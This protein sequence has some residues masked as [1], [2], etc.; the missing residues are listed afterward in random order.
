MYDLAILD[1]NVNIGD[2]SK[3]KICN[4]GIKDSKISYIGNEKINASKVINAVGYEVT[5]GFIDLHT[6]SD[7]SFIVDP[8]ADSKLV[9][10]VTFELMGNCGMSF[11]SPLSKDN[12]YQLQER[13]NRYGIKKNMD[14]NNFD[15]WLNEIENNIPSINVAAQIGHGNLR[16]Y[17]MGMEARQA[18]PEEI[19]EMKEEIQ[20]ACDQGVLGFSTGLWYAPGSYSS[21]E[22]IIELARIASKN[23]ILY[24]SHIRSES[25]DSSGLFPAHAEAI[26]IA[27]RSD[28]RVQISHVKSVGPKF[29]GRGYELIEGIEKARNESLDV[30]GDQYPYYWSSTPISGCMFPRW[31]LEGGRNKTIN[32]MKDLEIRKKI[33][34][35]TTNYIN[36]FHGPEGCILADYPS[37]K[38]FEGLNLNEISKELNTSPEEAV[39]QL[40]EKSE[41]SF[42]LHSMEEKDV[43]EIAKYKYMCVASDGNSLR[44][45][46]PLSSGKPHPRS[47]GTNTRFI[48]Q[49]VSNKKIVNFEEAIFRM[50]S[51]PA[52][53]MALKRRGR[54]ALNYFADIN[55]FKINELKENATYVSPHQYSTGMKNVIVN[56]KISVVDGKKIKGRNGK[57]IRSFSD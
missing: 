26:E 32:R 35:E 43:N 33:K 52:E 22:E 18:T 6:H 15:D 1:G 56:G 11:C 28:V 24:S 30:A 12:K 31:S 10:G 57:V 29:W 50:T 16:S 53:R 27:R 13:L 54:I 3:S 2:L 41:G 42:I 14:W 49:F 21:A 7:L 37:N 39:M 47:Y 9:Q 17:V 4:I 19:N 5:P 34:E 48:E 23:N 55:I 25:D 51:Y 40:Y 8:E 20:R 38:N 36:R 46:G 44:N 45:N